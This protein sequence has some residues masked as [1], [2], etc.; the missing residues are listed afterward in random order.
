MDWEVFRISRASAICILLLSIASMLMSLRLTHRVQSF[1]T[2]LF[3]W[4]SPTA[5]LTSDAIEQ[6]KSIGNRFSELVS[7]HQDNKK[8]KNEVMSLSLSQ[9]NYQEIAQENKRLKELLELKSSLNFD[10]TPAQV[11]GRDTH[12][13]S[14]A[15]WINRGMNDG[16]DLDCPVLSV[17]HDEN[18]AGKVIGGVIGR[19][20]KIGSSSSKVLLIADP[21]S[22]I[23][24][25][26]PRTGEQGLVQGQGGFLVTLEYMDPSADI[27]INDEVLTSGLGGLFP[28][29]LPIG[30]IKEIL[31]S[32]LGFKRASLEL[33]VHLNNLKEV[34]IL[35][36]SSEIEPKIENE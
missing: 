35:K 25:C 15:I 27:A 36:P 7:A 29:G 11:F 14:A 19:V 13:W 16:I 26:L 2:L 8:L 23:A 30:K 4:I 6:T 34:L 3:Y 31:T 22:S 12:N 24:V 10:T 17:A 18:L 5:S 28:S 1:R 33:N 20:L 32:P 9:A 21:L